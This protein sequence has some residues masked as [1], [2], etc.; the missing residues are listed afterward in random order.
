MTFP[1]RLAYIEFWR[2]HPALRDEWAPWI[3]EFSQHDLAGTEPE[4]R[5]SCRLDAVRFDGA[6]CMTDDFV[7]SLP[8]LAVLL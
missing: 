8:V 2:S 1:S 6:G 5:S 4:L 7:G 3:E